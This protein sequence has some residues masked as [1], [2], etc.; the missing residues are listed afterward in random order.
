MCDKRFTILELHFLIWQFSISQQG[1]SVLQGENQEQPSPISV[2]VP[3]FEEE[4]GALLG[5]SRR[6]EPDAHGNYYFLFILTSCL[7]LV[8]PS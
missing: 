1:A 5:C 8:V 6:I 3:P 4:D 2:L 7:I